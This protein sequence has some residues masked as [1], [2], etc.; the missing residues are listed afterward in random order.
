MCIPIPYITS[1]QLQLYYTAAANSISFTGGNL[2]CS[3]LVYSG[4]TITLNLNNLGSYKLVVSFRLF[5]D[6]AG[7]QYNISLNSTT[8]T[9]SLNSTNNTYNSSTF[10][11]SS[12]GYQICLNSNSSASYYAHIS[13][14]TFS[15]VKLQNTLKFT[16]VSSTLKL[17]ISE[18]LIVA[19]KCSS[20]CL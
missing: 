4:S 19:Y 9:T 12:L 18:I 8:N 1:T 10:T 15:S 3:K 20:L 2:M 14:T 5:T 6:I 11:S 13:N 17:H 7:Q 16:S